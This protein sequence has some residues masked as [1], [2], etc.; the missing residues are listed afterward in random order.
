MAWSNLL[1]IQPATIGLLALAINILLCS[2]SRVAAVFALPGRL[3]SRMIATL[4]ARYNTAYATEKA[5]RADS[6]SI[7]IFLAI[8]GL[9]TGAAL[10]YGLSLVYGGWVIE[11]ALIAMLITPRPLLERLRI[12]RHSLDTEPLEEAR[13]TVTLLTGRD[14]ADA[15]LATLRK[16]VSE[17]TVTGIVQG[18]VSPV[19]WFIV[20][21][22]PLL[23]VAKLQDTASIMIDEKSE[24]ARNFG[25][26]PRCVSAVMLTPASWI[27][28]ALLALGAALLPGLS[29]RGA[30]RESFAG[31]RYAWPVFSPAIRGLAGALS[32]RLGGDV[33]IGSFHRAGEEMG[34]A[35]EITDSCTRHTRD[36]LL[37]TLGA[38]VLAL[39]AM[40]LLGAPHVIL[41]L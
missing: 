22:L 12:L 2:G 1:E 16:V 28:A 32:C 7:A 3:A 14:V 41:P 36:L 8:V 25:A 29:G 13:A 20:G 37:A 27:T 18:T 9:A 38:L 24:D 40:A 31:Q 15:D 23:A 21:G 39:L 33:C 5:R 34:P 30:L 26:A 19:F 6:I 35:T 4:E 11:A 10:D 17:S